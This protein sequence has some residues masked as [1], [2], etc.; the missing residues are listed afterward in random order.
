MAGRGSRFV[1]AG[2]ELDNPLIPIHGVPMIELVVRNLTPTREHRFIFV[3]QREHIE[4]YA[5]DEALK[6]MAVGCEVLA[7]DE[8][9]EG[10]ACTVLLTRELIDGDDPL[11][12]ANSDQ[13]V[14]CSVDDYLARMRPIAMVMELFPFPAPP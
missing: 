7:I 10:A 14:D 1:A 13:W 6:A 11:M 8:V 12:I 4:R 3:C 5:V 9:T 2:Y